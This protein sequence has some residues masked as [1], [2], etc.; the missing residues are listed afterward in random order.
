MDT[1]L[2]KAEMDRLSGLDASFLYLET[3]AQLMHVCGLIVLDPATMPE[4]LLVRRHARRHRGQGPRRPGVHAQAAPGAA[5]ARPPGLGAGHAVRHRAARAPARAADAGRVRRAHRAGRPP[6]RPPARP[7]PPAVGDVGDRGLPGRG[8]PRAGRGL[9]EDAPRHR[10]RR[11]RRQPD[12]APVQP[13][14]GRGAARRSAGEEGVAARARPSRAV[15][16]RARHQRH[17]AVHDLRPD[18]ADR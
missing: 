10:R 16:A 9:P 14:A 18:G 1:C 4:P 3:P 13:R 2:R 11:L 8:R 15:R 7:L 17:P 6:R 5:R 12:L